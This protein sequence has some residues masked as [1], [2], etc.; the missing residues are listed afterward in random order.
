[1]FGSI[2]NAGLYFF[3]PQLYELSEMKNLFERQTSVLFVQIDLN[4]VYNLAG[5]PFKFQIS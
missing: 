2:K 3:L 5:G 4:Y 1:M